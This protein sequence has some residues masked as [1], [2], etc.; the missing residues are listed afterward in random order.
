MHFF[1]SI[2]SF[3]EGM[4]QFGYI[5]AFLFAFTESLALIGGFVPGSTAVVIFGFMAS[6]GYLSVPGLIVFT[7]L[8]A[9]IGDG[10]SYW[11]GTKG[12]HL[13]KNENRIL[14]ASHLE[15][16]K[17]FFHKYGDKSIFL[18]RFIGVVRPMIPFAAG[19]ARMNSRKFLFWNI[20]SGIVWGISHIYLGYFFGGMLKIIETVS[21]R[22]SIFLLI[23]VILGMIIWFSV[24]LLK[25]TTYWLYKLIKQTGVRFWSHPAIIKLSY[26]YPYLTDI[27]KRRFEEKN[28]FGWTM[29]VVGTMISFIAIFF[30]VLMDGVLDADW[31]VALDQRFSG[32][33]YYFRDAWAVKISLWVSLLGNYYIIILIS[34]LFIIFLYIWNKKHFLYSYLISLGGSVLVSWLI[35]ITAMRPRPSGFL[36]VY[37]E[38]LSSFPSGHSVVAVSVYCFIIYVLT[39]LL[40]RSTKTFYSAFLIFSGV[41]IAFLIGLSRIYLGV[42]YLSDVLGGFLIGTLFLI[43]AA[44]IA[45]WL[46]I[47]KPNE[48]NNDLNKN[49]ILFKKYMSCFLV[50][51]FVISYGV[52]GTW[53][54][55]PLP[56]IDRGIKENIVPS[57]V[58]TEELVRTNK[59]AV[60]AD[61]LL[62]GIHEPINMFVWAKNDLVLHQ[63]LKLSNWLVA[64]DPTIKSFFKISRSV[65]MGRTYESIPVLPYFWNDIPNDLAFEKMVTDSAKKQKKQL[66]LWKTLIQNDKGEYL[67]VGSV[68]LD[69]KSRWGIVYR[70]DKQ[71]D[72]QREAIF[73]ELKSSNSISTSS[74]IKISEPLTVNN[75]RFVTD[76]LARVVYLK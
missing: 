46:Q 63:S 65:A 43:L 44:T 54:Y 27:V 5:V 1:L 70:V 2:L 23:L 69:I 73:S 10:V 45:E 67:Y 62:G 40:R 17:N 33:L 15:I 37:Q 18:G 31:I 53:F 39:R 28:F 29:T 14:K 20:V 64:D 58:I 61:G 12:T 60:T 6:Q 55:K 3:V 4:G 30:A 48:G 59:W 38:T 22:L 68:S 72:L 66:R 35:K 9:V 49:N 51:V 16:G 25:P 7:V 8:G 19:L 57:S 11:L 47:H 24:K 56:I 41:L 34:I 52:Y 76:G 50:L 75:S 26:R 71:I 21:V 32:L 42:H 74:L 36:P 13:F